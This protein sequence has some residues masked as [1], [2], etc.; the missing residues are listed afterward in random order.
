MPNASIDGLLAPNLGYDMASST[1]YKQW[2]QNSLVRAA[3]DIVMDAFHFVVNFGFSFDIDKFLERFDLYL[4]ASSSDH[5][6]IDMDYLL[7]INERIM[8]PLSED[9]AAYYSS[10]HEYDEFMTPFSFYLLENVFHQTFVSDGQSNVIHELLKVSGNKENLRHYVHNA[11]ANFKRFSENMLELRPT[12][13]PL[14]KEDA[15]R[16]LVFG[17]GFNGH[18]FNSPSRTLKNENQ[19]YFTFSDSGRRD[20]GYL[21]LS[22]IKD[23]AT[24]YPNKLTQSLQTRSVHDLFNQYKDLIRYIVG[25][26]TRSPFFVDKDLVVTDL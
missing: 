25:P 1:S 8:Q 19:I 11:L 22:L 12:D 10:K 6:I 21:L 23:I 4:K 5:E 18:L 13:K 3:G 7:N 15:V 17:I 14:K 2:I 20:G 16:G 26:K 9:A 24:R